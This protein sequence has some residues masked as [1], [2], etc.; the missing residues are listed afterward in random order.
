MHK[1]VCM[2]WRARAPTPVLVI[3]MHSARSLGGACPPKI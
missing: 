3:C 2:R 1:G